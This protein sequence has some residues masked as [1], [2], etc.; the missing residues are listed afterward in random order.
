MEKNPFEKH[1]PKK[2]NFSEMSLREKIAYWFSR[3]KLRVRFYSRKTL[4]PVTK[5][6]VS[7][8]QVQLRDSSTPDFDYF[9]MVLLS[10]MIATF[11][12]LIDSAATIIGAMLVAP[13]M[14]PILGIGLA[15]IRG[16]TTLLRDA[17]SALLRGALLAV[18]LSALITWTNSLLPFISMQ[19]LPVEVL[20]RTRPSPIDLGVALAGGLAATF[21]LVQPNLSAAL[22]GVAIATALMPPLC[23]IGVGLAL[24]RWDVAEGALLLFVTNSVTIAASS[25]FLFYITGFSLGRKQDDRLIPRSLQISILLI[26]VLLAPL[27]WQS[28]VF[29]Q[30]A[31]FTR[32]LEQ[33]VRQ[34]VQN[35]GA[36]LD[37]FS[38][39]ETED[40]VLVMDITVL[41][42][43]SLRYSNSVE[44]Q[45]A[46]ATRLQRAV[47][48]KI[49]QVNVAQLDPAIPPTLTP[50]VLATS[51]TTP[52]VTATATSTVTTTPTPT[53]TYTPTP[54]Q[55]YTPT[56]EMAVLDEGSRVSL[57]AH[58]GGP[59]IGVIYRNQPFKV[60]YG[61]QIYDGWVWIEVEDQEG[62]VGW[63]PQY[64]SGLVTRTPTTTPSLTPSLTP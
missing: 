23:V 14:S 49:N 34:E 42:S 36:T 63:I 24:G 25:T 61:T 30:D 44:L 43:Q 60:L 6:R 54:T 19:D 1:L 9:V 52:T 64:L 45:D 20:S 46:I 50:T 32:E 38:W 37:K 62:R 7:E 22:P 8:V 16:D 31:S 56:P 58:P 39:D 51:T 28:Y 5:E 57:L 2:P 10:C 21:A 41:V 27:G 40:N 17:G 4:P 13:L 29:V 33:V 35:V 48:L 11:G 12:L 47:Q 53:F 15:S 18:F 26:V 55:T 59:E 3:F